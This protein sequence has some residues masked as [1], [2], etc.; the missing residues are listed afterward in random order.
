MFAIRDYKGVDQLYPLHIARLFKGSVNGKKCH[1]D[2]FDGSYNQMVSKS[3]EDKSQ[4]LGVGAFLDNSHFGNHTVV[5][6]K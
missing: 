3:R 4:L 1:P 5:S 6:Q 2:F